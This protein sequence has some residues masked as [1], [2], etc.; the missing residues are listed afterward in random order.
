MRQLRSFGWIVAH[1]SFVD[2][3]DKSKSERRQL[4]AAELGELGIISV[5]DSE[6]ASTTVQSEVAM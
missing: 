5:E 2:W 4:V 1:I 6:L 3:N